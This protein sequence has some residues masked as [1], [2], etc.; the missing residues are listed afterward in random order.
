MEKKL[1]RIPDQAVFGGVASGI[2]Q[3]LQ[4]DVVIV[5]ILFVVML[6]LPIP[7]SFGWTG[8]LYIILW[9][10]LPTGPAA[11]VYTTSFDSNASRTPDPVWDKK[12]SDQTVMILGGV[13]IFFGAVM[14]VDDFPIWYQF[15]QYFWPLILIAIGAFLILRQRDKD[16]ESNTTVYPTT[17]PPVDPVKPDPDPQPYTPFSPASTTSASHFPEDPQNKKRDD[18]DDDQIIKVN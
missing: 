4:I 9:A 12:R 5:R 17:P 6:L 2:A 1:H 14:L 11:D 15:K 16:Q 18:E 7:P 8:I 3:Y 13:L 10:V